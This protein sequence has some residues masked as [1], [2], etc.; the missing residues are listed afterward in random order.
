L[1]PY[2]RDMTLSLRVALPLFCAVLLS[3]SCS[4]SPRVEAAATPDIPTVAVAKVGLENLSHDL[5]LTA[6]FKPYQEIDVMAKVAGY[7]KEIRGDVGDRGKQGH[8]L[9]IRETPD[10]ADDLKR[11]ASNG[12]PSHGE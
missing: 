5:V 7:I 10:I 8:L 9:G 3:T 2:H 4:Q 1:L 11:S 6:E 12:K